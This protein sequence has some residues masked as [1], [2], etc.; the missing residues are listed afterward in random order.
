MSTFIPKDEANLN[1]NQFIPQKRSIT[2]INWLIL[3]TKIIAVNSENPTKPIQ[4]GKN[5]ELLNFKG[6][7]THYAL[8]CYNTALFN[9]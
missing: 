8:K 7:G 5:V 3:F 9:V 6:D 2:I 4:C 1:Y